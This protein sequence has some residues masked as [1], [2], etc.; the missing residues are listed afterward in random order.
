MKIQKVIRA[1]GEFAKVNVD[2]RDGDSLVIK[3][4]GQIIN[5]DFGDRHVFKVLTKNGDRNLSFNQTSLNNLVDAYGEDTRNWIGKKMTAFVIKQM[6]GEGLKNVCYLAGEGWTMT[7]EGK[8]LP[9]RS[10]PKV[11]GTDMDYPIND[12]AEV[13]F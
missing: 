3:D 7:D 4:E 11:G 8:F 9:P 13:G 2:F 5:G 1:Q 6:V 10:T 12:G